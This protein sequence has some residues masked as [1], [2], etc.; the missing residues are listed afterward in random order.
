MKVIASG[1]ALSYA[2]AVSQVVAEGGPAALFV[3]GLR[4]KLVANGVQ[5]AL[6]TVLW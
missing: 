1:G 6:F 2:G 4:L 3:R 5:S